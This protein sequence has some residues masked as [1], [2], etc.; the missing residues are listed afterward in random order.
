MILDLMATYL[1]MKFIFVLAKNVLL[2]LFI[3]FSFPLLSL[4][5]IGHIQ[6]V[7]LLTMEE[8]IL[9]ERHVL[10]RKISFFSD[11]LDKLDKH[12]GTTTA[13]VV[14]HGTRCQGYLS[15]KDAPSKQL[16]KSVT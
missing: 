14:V 1:E 5:T 8:A 3:L 4:V 11:L 15:C 6:L 7:V 2:Y 16:F 12:V 10:H 13:N 9:S